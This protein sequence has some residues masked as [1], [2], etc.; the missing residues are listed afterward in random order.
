M[1]L[2]G[3]TKYERGKTMSK[4]ISIAQ[5]LRDSGLTVSLDTKDNEVSVS[6]ADYLITISEE[7]GQFSATL[8]AGS[9]YSC[10][11][12]TH[13]EELFTYRNPKAVA[14]AVAKRVKDLESLGE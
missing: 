12:W 4:L 1:K 13:E 2:Q 5:T 10:N 6:G 8:F 9:D 3:A 11:D 14:S 7:L